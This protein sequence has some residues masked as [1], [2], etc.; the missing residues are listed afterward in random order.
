MNTQFDIEK[1]IKQGEIKNELELE[2]ALIAER[3]LRVLSK[4]NPEYKITRKQLR[5]LIERYEKVFWSPD[6]KIS[7]KKLL[8]SDVVEVIAEKERIF[9]ANR[10]ELIKSKIKRL[11]LNQQDFGKILGH[12]S[13]SYISELMNGIRPFSLKDLVIINRVLQIDLKDLIPTFLPLDERKKITTS[14][15]KLDNPK[16]KL[17][18]DDFAVV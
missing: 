15:K 17:N 12:T 10:K 3:K 2:R 5:D 16:L 18:E 8:E 14:I 1:L 13:K 9:I 11:N 4:E 7:E 6:S